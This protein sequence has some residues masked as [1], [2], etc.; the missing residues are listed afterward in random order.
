MLTFKN[1][2]RSLVLI[3]WRGPTPKPHHVRGAIIS[4]AV[5]VF[6]SKFHDN[7]MR[8]LEAYRVVGQCHEEQRK[9]GHQTVGAVVVV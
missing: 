3:P 1:D 6:S 8:V 2:R 7:G 9:D 4:N 5:I